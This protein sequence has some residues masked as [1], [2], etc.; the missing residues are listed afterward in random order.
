M[1]WLA[2]TFLGATL[3]GESTGAAIA[4]ERHNGRHTRVF[5]DEMF[6]KANNSAVIYGQYGSFSG[7]SGGF[8]APAGH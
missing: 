7:Y 5:A 4:A 8:S 6:R 3:I 2:I 1:R